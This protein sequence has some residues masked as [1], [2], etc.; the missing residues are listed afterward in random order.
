[1]SQRQQLMINEAVILRHISYT[2]RAMLP[3]PIALTYVQT[4]F[5]PGSQLEYPRKQALARRAFAL[6]NSALF[7][8]QL[9]YVTH[10]PHALAIAAIYLAARETGVRIST[11]EW[12]LVW[13]VTREELG[14]LVLALRS[15][16]MWLR[17]REK[18]AKPFMWTARSVDV[19]LRQQEAR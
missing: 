9:L 2:T 6:L 7:S 16:E 3:H 5:P 14:F 4:L 8:P 13:D 12:W 17:V 18:T 10:Q 15:I 1:M 11:E 19:E